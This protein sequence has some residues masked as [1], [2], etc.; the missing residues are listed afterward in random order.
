MRAIFANQFKLTTKIRSI[1]E[2]ETRKKSE[3]RFNSLIRPINN[4]DRAL[5][6]SRLALP[7]T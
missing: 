7:V 1:I 4:N 2:D 3:L 5:L 6:T